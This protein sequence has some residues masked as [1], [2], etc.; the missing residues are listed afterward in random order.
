MSVLHIHT[1]ILAL[2]LMKFK[3]KQAPV[4]VVALIFALPTGTSAV[5]PRKKS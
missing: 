2:L 5:F 1:G 4:S 3:A